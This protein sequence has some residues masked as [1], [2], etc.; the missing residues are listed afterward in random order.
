MLNLVPCVTFVFITV[1]VCWCGSACSKQVQEATLPT[2]PREQQSRLKCFMI[3]LSSFRYLKLDHVRNAP[4]RRFICA[5]NQPRTGSLSFLKCG[6]A[7]RYI[8]SHIA[9]CGSVWF[10]LVVLS[11]GT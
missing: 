11:L 5:V 7:G 9:P 8:H 1:A 10:R 6:T 3:F 2:Q 4:S